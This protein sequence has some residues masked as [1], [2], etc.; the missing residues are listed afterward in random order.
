M[1]FLDLLQMMLVRVWV[2]VRPGEETNLQ[3]FWSRNARGGNPLAL[4]EDLR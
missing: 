4:N 1:A 3:G 2:Y